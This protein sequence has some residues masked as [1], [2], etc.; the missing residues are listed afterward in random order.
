MSQLVPEGLPAP[1]TTATLDIN[2]DSPQDNER[3]NQLFQ[4]GLT[5]RATGEL[6]TNIDVDV[7]TPAPGTGERQASAPS[8]DDSDDDVSIGGMIWDV[9]K[10]G[11]NGAANAGI[12]TAD[13]FTETLADV[14]LSKYENP[15]GEQKTA[16]GRIVNDIATF[17]AGFWTGGKILKSLKLLQGAGKVTAFARGAAQGA[18]SDFFTEDG[19]AE[20]L[21]ALIQKNDTLRNVITESLATSKDSEEFTGRLK[22]AFEGLA[23]GVLTEPLAIIIG[24]YAKPVFRRLRKNGAI[25][26]ALEEGALKPTHED[27][28]EAFEQL[29]KLPSET[30]AAFMD[31]LDQPD[32]LLDSAGKNIIKEP[33]KAAPFAN[34]PDNAFLARTADDGTDPAMRGIPKRLAPN[35]EG[36]VPP[37]VMLHEEKGRDTLRQVMEV[38]NKSTDRE[39]AIRALQENVTLS[40]KILNDP[41]AL[42]LLEKV[43]TSLDAKTLKAQGPES[44]DMLKR[45]TDQMADRYGMPAM[46]DLF[47]KAI[48]GEIPLKDARHAARFIQMSTDFVA[49]NLVRLARQYKMN[50]GELLLKDLA[51]LDV[52]KTNLDNLYLAQRN[53]KTLTGRTLN[54]FKYLAS[55]D[56]AGNTK[57]AQWVTMPVGRSVEDIKAGLASRGWNR[58]KVDRL[59]TDVLANTDDPARIAKLAN[60]FD[61]ASKMG[62]LNEFRINNMLSGPFTIGANALGNALKTVAMPTERYLAGVISGNV[63]MRQEAV[64]TFAGLVQFTSEAW[65]LGKKAAKIGDS[66]MDNAAGKL[67]ANASAQLT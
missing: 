37:T 46:Q 33:E 9:V 61:T 50:G 41:D 14:D 67:E 53:I 6:P 13:F 29:E 65:R 57:V 66:I 30:K 22:H 43:H 20:N 44:I 17:V 2:A 27:I 32:G 56:S 3:L 5:G 19:Q 28:Q 7:S 48:S 39:S 15:L 25:E 31:R 51:K 62:I 42:G 26:E 18:F 34:D 54:S 55:V 52:L 4:A 21:S 60:R 36:Y 24:T 63:A 47:K 10:G 35:A 45:E 49:S 38:I 16:A 64:D 1:E 23:L 12:E 11:F 59:L 40:D 58:K 8:A